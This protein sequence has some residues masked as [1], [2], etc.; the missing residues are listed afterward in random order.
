M[1]AYMAANRLEM[2]VVCHGGAVSAMNQAM[3]TLVTSMMEKG[4]CLENK[5][6]A[7]QILLGA[8]VAQLEGVLPEA[9]ADVVNEIADLQTQ[10]DASDFERLAKNTA[11]ATLTGTAMDP[12]RFFVLR[13]ATAMHVLSGLGGQ[14]S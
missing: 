14:Q 7:F 12:R 13:C 9:W 1:V 4:G 10:C 2:P 8:T 11:V 5:A 3:M 6:E